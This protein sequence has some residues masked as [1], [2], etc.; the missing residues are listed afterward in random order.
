MHTSTELWRR[1]R[2]G[3]AVF[4]L[5][6]AVLILMALCYPAVM[7]PYKMGMP[8]K[9]VSELTL[10]GID[11]LRKYDADELA[12]YQW[13]AQSPYGVVSEAIGSYQTEFAQYPR[14]GLP[15]V[16]GWGGHEAQWRGGSEEM[17]R[18]I[19]I[20]LRSTRQGI[21]TRQNPSSIVIEIRYIYIGE[22][23]QN[24]Q[25]RGSKICS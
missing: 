13:L 6:W 8:G 7:L 2:V 21:G 25:S 19:L 20:S 11:Y 9:A 4:R 17:S 10:D 23:L 3:A 16:L 24:L 12:A 22:W 14:T 1:L 5:G 15:T 18:A